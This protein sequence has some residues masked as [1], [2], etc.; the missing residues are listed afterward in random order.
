M[1]ENR[2]RQ[3]FQSG[4][5]AM[6]MFVFIP[7]GTIVDLAGYAGFDYLLFDTE[8]VSYDLGAMEN[9]QR[10][11]EAAQLPTL[12]RVPHPDPYLI[13]RILDMGVDGILCAQVSSKQ[14]AE[15][16]VRFC[17]IPPVGE[18]GACPGSRSAKYRLMS[19]DEYH[20]RTNDA[21]ISIMIESK[22]GVEHAEEI[23]SVPGIDGV[24]VGGDDLAASLGVSDREH[25]KVSEA[26]KH[27]IKVAESA[28]VTFITA[29]TTTEVLEYWLQSE[30]NLRIFHCTTDAWQIGNCFRGFVQRSRELAG[31]HHS[32]TTGI[33]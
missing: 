4:R 9:L 23:L 1:E 19:S 22:E 28:G 16:L 24:I 18:R 12:V 2:L 11:A 30:K 20:R 3:L 17:R 27:V 26:R 31:K 29:V 32:D 15:D 33:K 25:P 13:A 5:F 8:H 6:G 14:Q 21:V 7:S 10:T